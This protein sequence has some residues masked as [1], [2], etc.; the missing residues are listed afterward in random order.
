MTGVTPTD[1]RRMRADVGELL[2]HVQGSQADQQTADIL[3]RIADEYRGRVL[4]FADAIGCPVLDYQEAF[5]QSTIDNKKTAWAAAHGVG[6]DYTIG[7]L[8]AY[9]VLVEGRRSLLISGTRTQVEGQ[10]M[11]EARRAF[12]GAAK[13]FGLSFDFYRGSIRIGGEDRVIALSGGS[14]ADNLQGWHYPGGDFI[15]ISEGQ[16]Q[17]TEDAA[18]DA[19]EV[20]ASS[21]NGRIAVAGNPLRPYG[22][23]YESFQRGTWETFYTSFYDT[24]N[25]KEGR[26]VIPSMSGPEWGDQMAAERGRDSADYIAR[27]LGQFPQD[28]EDVAIP[29]DKRE[30]ARKYWTRPDTLD[31]ADLHLGFDPAGPGRDSNCLCIL[32]KHHNAHA[33]R[34]FRLWKGLDTVETSRRVA[35]IVTELIE[36]GA[37]VRTLLIDAV[38]LGEGV[39]DWLQRLLKHVTYRE[40]VQ[41]S[42]WDSGP[43]YRDRR[44]EVKS[45]KASRRAYRPDQFRNLRSESFFNL[46]EEFFQGRMMI[47]PDEELTEEL[48]ALRMRIGST[49]LTEF[50]G[51]DD[52]KSQLGRSP[53]RC[54]ALAIAL[55]YTLTD[56]REKRFILLP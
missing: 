18:Y 56:P 5:G 51:K 7:V 38:G 44:V 27:V 52:M 43:A 39:S 25:A 35:A 10:T 3:A 23:F 54:D 36:G 30:A 53:D 20:C 8:S 24:P 37:M 29:A 31:G 9:H 45:F 17:Q 6:K 55:S 14:S 1:L 46:R 4:A 12:R 21:A 16:A 13:A 34:E 22:R 15:A 33:V 28:A 19:A 32:E 50:V 26:V 40:Q 48:A 2:E 41:R 11:A 47:P 49:G 42:V